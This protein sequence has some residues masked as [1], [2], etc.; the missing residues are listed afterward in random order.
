M[1]TSYVKSWVSRRYY[2]YDLPSSAINAWDVLGATVYNNQ[3][4]SSQATVKSILE[5]APALSGLVNRPGPPQPTIV[6]YDTDTT[7]VPALQML[8]QAGHESETLLDIPEFKYDLVDVTRQL[9]ANRFIALYE[10]LVAIFTS[11]SSSSAAIIA[12]GQPLLQLLRDLDELLLTDDYFLLA[13]WISAARSWSNGNAS[14]AAFLENNA[15][16]QITLWG[17]TGEINDYASKQWGGLIG[18]YYVPRWEAFIDY[19]V[20]MKGNDT[21]YNATAVANT[22]VAIGEQWDAQTWGRA[23]SLGTVGDTWSIVQILAMNPDEIAFCRHTPNEE[24]VDHDTTHSHVLSCFTRSILSPRLSCL[25]VSLSNPSFLDT[26]SISSFHGET[27]AKWR[28]AGYQEQ[29]GYENFKEVL[30]NPVTDAQDLPVDCF[31]IH[32]L[33][34]GRQSSTIP[35]IEA[36]S[37][38]DA[39]VDVDV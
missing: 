34:S 33:R 16:N 37:V 20:E 18:G 23:G 39:H 29:E 24:L 38:D 1:M 25:T 36:Q 5:L 2:V 19:L 8:I 15:R 10:T 30:E 26:F 21:A 12:A 28:K 6:F 17:P 4:P 22:M 32:R 13:N 9:L 3:D 31:P 14:Y 7:I 35:A 27:V 11:N